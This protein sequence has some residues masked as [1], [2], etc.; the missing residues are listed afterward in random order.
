MKVDE[1]IEFNHPK[2]HFR[3]TDHN[4]NNYQDSQSSGIIAHLEPLVFKAKDANFSVNPT[5]PDEPKPLKIDV[6]INYIVKC[7][8]GKS[9]LE[10]PMLDPKLPTIPQRHVTL[11]LRTG[12]KQP[13]RCQ[14]DMEFSLKEPNSYEVTV[15]EHQALQLEFHVS[16][17]G[18]EPAY[19]VTIVFISVAPFTKIEGPRG[20][21]KLS[22]KK[23]YHSEP[24]FETECTL[25]KIA[26]SKDIQAKFRFQ[27]PVDFNG[28]ES[29]K[30][31]P[32]MLDSCNGGP[33]PQDLPQLQNRLFNLRFDANIEVKTSVSSVTI[34]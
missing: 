7:P 12:C 10:C 20:V 33:N 17:K 26:E 4:V 34:V 30:I 14:C 6:K 31:I 2:P 13:E 25:P 27:F 15:G 16:N 19:G 18:K 22:E 11:Y 32:V 28:T 1:R 9:L 3:I 23:R 24:G 29:F 5:D 21:C 8:S